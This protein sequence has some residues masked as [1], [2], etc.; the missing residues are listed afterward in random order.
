M[1][2]FA[3][4][5]RTVSRSFRDAVLDT[6]PAL[7]GD[8]E[9]ALG[10][11]RIAEYCLFGT[12]RYDTAALLAS[13][14]TIA[15]LVG[16]HPKTRGFWT[17][18]WLDAFDAEVFPLDVTDARYWEGKARTMRPDIPAE[19]LTAR[20]RELN[21]D[22][23]AF[24]QE[25]VDFVAGK[26]VSWLENRRAIA[27]YE[28]E[29]EPHEDEVI[30]VHP[31]QELLDLLNWQSIRSLDRVLRA[32]WWELVAQYEQMPQATGREQRRRESAL[33]SLL[34]IQESHRMVYVASER[35]PRIFARGAPI[36]LLPRELRAVALQGNAG[37]DLK[38]CQLA[39]LARVCGINSLQ[40]FLD[41]RRSI[42]EE[43]LSFLD[44]D[45]NRKPIL[46][47][48]IYAL[49]FGMGR[50]KLKAQ[51]ADGTELIEGVS[52]EAARRFF[53]HPLIHDL[54]EARGAAFERISE[55]G[56]ACDAF[57]RWIPLYPYAAHEVLAQQAQ[58][59]ELKIMLAAL[60]VLQNEDVTI[61]SWLHDGMTVRTQ[62]RTKEARRIRQIAGAVN[63]EAARLGIS[64]E[65][66]VQP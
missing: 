13:R 26:K 32:N 36:N 6:C 5:P 21:R 10:Y 19:I 9:R 47:G 8:T 31:A 24:H 66:E 54:L 17:K 62:N 60:P 61:L 38:A 58:S 53:E 37:L 55:G 7:S 34:R 30:P 20:E 18:D 15:A 40:D 27:E 25:R 28:Q 22:P 2:R 48:S 4:F 59:Y 44:L 14:D 43:L 29:L 56:G 16:V 1:P 65:L 57:G 50:R 45:E 35:T 46:K 51:L 11:R 41:T 52:T 64:T 23:G 3:R 39:V 49:V 42:W 33:R 12:Y 63:A